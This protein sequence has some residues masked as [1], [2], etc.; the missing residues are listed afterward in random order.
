MN[1]IKKIL[2]IILAFVLVFGSCLTVSAEE[3]YNLSGFELY[4]YTCIFRDNNSIGQIK[5]ITSDSEPYYAKSQINFR[6]SLHYSYVKNSTTFS[7]DV[8]D[9]NKQTGGSYITVSY[10]ELLYSNFDICNES[11]NIF[12]RKPVTPDTDNTYSNNETEGSILVTAEVGSTYTI[13]L[14]ATL[15]LSYNE[16]S[17]KYE[18][19]YTV[20]VKANLTEGE[21]VSVT[22]TTSFTLSETGGGSEEGSVTQTVNTWKLNASA[23]N[24]IASDYQNFVETKGKVSA[25]LTKAGTY[26]GTLDFTFAKVTN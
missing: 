23:A 15:A 11:G 26:N 5:I 22:P 19:D 8:N 21:S 6:D 18:G 10:P 1:K 24:E 13:S 20:S 9:Y 3:N 17:G 16:T 25:N 7:S 12:F 4:K 2:P 14:P